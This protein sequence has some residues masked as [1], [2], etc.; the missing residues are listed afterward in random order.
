MN[1]VS[2]DLWVRGEVTPS[3]VVAAIGVDARWLHNESDPVQHRVVTAQLASG[4]AEDGSPTL[5]IAVSRLEAARAGLTDLI[6]RSLDVTLRC[7]LE[8]MEVWESYFALSPNL[9]RRMAD[10]GLAV[11][12]L[13]LCLERE[14]RTPS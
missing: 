6:R 13:P 10:L 7:Q 14:E 12:I 8:T 1:E 9:L 3:D 11:E 2:V 4:H 5:E